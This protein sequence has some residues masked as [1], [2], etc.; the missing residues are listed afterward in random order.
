MYSVTIDTSQEVNVDAM[1]KESQQ[2]ENIYN[3]FMPFRKTPEE[4]YSEICI[5]V[6]KENREIGT[7]D[8]SKIWFQYVNELK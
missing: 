8:N 5:Q 6:L 3:R 7:Y 2:L 1:P 4:M